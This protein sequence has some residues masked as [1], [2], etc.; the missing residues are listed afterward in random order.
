MGRNAHYGLL[1]DYGLRVF[2]MADWL[3]GDRE[4][5]P[6]GLFKRLFGGGLEYYFMALP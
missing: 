6:A 3:A 1:H 2:R 5:M 4:E